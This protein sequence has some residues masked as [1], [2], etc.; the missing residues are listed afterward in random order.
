MVHHFQFFAEVFAGHVDPPLGGIVAGGPAVDTA[1]EN[2]DVGVAQPLQ[3]GR[4]QRRAATV[5]VANDNL[6]ILG[7]HRF[8]HDEFDAAAGNKTGPRDVRAVV[9]AGLADV[10]QR[11]GLVT[12]EQ[13]VQLGVRY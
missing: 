3:G 12:L 4:G 7:R 5:V 11:K 6:H 1:V 9:L 13:A 2:G 8:L 10:Y